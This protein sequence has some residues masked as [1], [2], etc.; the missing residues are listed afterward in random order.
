MGSLI[1]NV[2]LLIVIVGAAKLVLHFVDKWGKFLLFLAVPAI[3]YSAPITPDDLQVL[4]D[5]AH[6]DAVILNKGLWFL[7][8]VVLAKCMFGNIKFYV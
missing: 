3:G 5:S 2:C 6:A 7:G 4:I 1:F 8:G